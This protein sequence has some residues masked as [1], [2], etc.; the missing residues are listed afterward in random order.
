MNDAM[1]LGAYWSFFIC[2]L[3]AAF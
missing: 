2:T 3:D 1:Y